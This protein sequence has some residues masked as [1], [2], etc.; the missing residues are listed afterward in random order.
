MSGA[1][2]RR[3]RARGPAA[4]GAPARARAPGCAAPAA[5]SGA[6]AGALDH[7]R[8]QP[9]TRCRRQGRKLGPSTTWPTR[10]AATRTANGCCGRCARCCACG[11]GRDS[12]GGDGMRLDHRVEHV[13]QLP[14]GRRVVDREHLAHATFHGALVDPSWAAVNR[15]LRRSWS[16]AQAPRAAHGRP[17]WPP[18]RPAR[19][20]GLPR[21]PELRAPG[22]ASRPCHRTGGAVSMTQHVGPTGP[23]SNPCRWAG[24]RSGSESPPSGPA[25]A[26]AVAPPD[27][28]RGP[29]R[30]SP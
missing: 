14:G 20:T 26:A 16:P 10:S 15:E 13:A 23:E 1:G 27:R 11:R 22:A 4:F 6:R 2:A 12:N 29:S 30:S 5:A 7:G 3:L 24:Y 25:A 19:D 21:R 8:R 28:P 18:W 9:A 17:W